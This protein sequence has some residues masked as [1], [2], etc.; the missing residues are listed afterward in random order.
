MRD[1]HSF[2]LLDE[3]WITVLDSDGRSTDVSLLDL[4]RQARTIRAIGGEIVTQDF[5]LLRL[6]L[7]IVT[8]ALDGDAPREARDVAE[9]TEVILEQWEEEFAPL[10][11]GYLER[12]RN[13]FDLFDPAQPFFQV[14]GMHTAKGEVSPPGKIIADVPAG[15][16]FLTMRSARSTRSISAAEAARWLVHTQAFDPSGIKTGVVG[17][18]RAKGGRVYPEGVAWTGQLGGLHLIGESLLHT[19]LLNLWAVLPNRA[20]RAV[21][22]PPWERE[23]AGL[24]PAPDLPARPAGPVDLYTW[25]PRR[26]LLRG[27]RN[28]VTGVLVTYGDTFVIQ[29][30]Q[31]TV[32]I[33]PMSLWRY[34][35]PQTRKYHESIQMPRAHQPNV[36]LW[37]GLAAVV[38]RGQRQ[39]DEKSAA[40]T[41]L[42]EHAA[43]LRRS[44]LLPHGLVRYRAI[45]VVY[46]SNN[47][48]IDEVIEDSLDLP[49]IALDPDARELR[50]VALSA[51]NAT[52]AGVAALAKLARQLAAAAGAGTDERQGPGDRAYE[53]A[54]AALDAPYRTWLRTT[55]ADAA[56]EPLLAEAT[57][58]AEARRILDQLGHDLVSQAPEKAWLGFGQTERRDDVGAVYQRFRRNLGTAFPRAK[59]QWNRDAAGDATSAMSDEQQEQ[60]EREA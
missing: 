22:L 21:D 57:W 2:N 26:V 32:N 34:S 24:G 38:P 7:A 8:R 36:S 52:K 27:D 5:A 46:G 56:D 54:Y 16:P 23:P 55:L 20:D 42:V 25:Q 3:P 4:V 30:R 33:E 53:N 48:V 40:I 29:Q 9:T 43:R 19:L 45:G 39:R 1:D 31:H 15:L 13:R 6:L 50:Q 28:G 12:H 49:A 35:D 18:P 17:H 51:V 44:S 41:Q 58:H 47:S 60:K 10:V 59:T 14:A 11:T 37:R